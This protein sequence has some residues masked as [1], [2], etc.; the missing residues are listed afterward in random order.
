MDATTS[1]MMGYQEDDVREAFRW[2]RNDRRG[3]FCCDNGRLASSRTRSSA[4]L[5][6]SSFF[7]R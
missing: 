2:L 1:S 3:M 5:S 6:D 4:L 7:I